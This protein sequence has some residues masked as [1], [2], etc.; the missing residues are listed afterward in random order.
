MHAPQ[1]HARIAAALLL[2][3]PAVAAAEA[4]GA[5]LAQEEEERPRAARVALALPTR[6]PSRSCSGVADLTAQ[7]TAD[8]RHLSR[9]G[10]CD[11]LMRVSLTNH[12]AS[13]AFCGVAPVRSGGAIEPPAYVT[14]RPGETASGALSWCGFPDGSIKVLCVEECERDYCLMEQWSHVRAQ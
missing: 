4:D 2:V 14:L 3:A 8:H 9:G 1:L 11:G 7:V 10:A 13:T 12:S 5:E 6:P